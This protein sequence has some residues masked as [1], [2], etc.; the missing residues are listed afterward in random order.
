MS[1]TTLS[2]FKPILDFIQHRSVDAQ[3]QYDLA[4]AFPLSSD[5]VQSIREWCLQGLKSGS[6]RVRGPQTLRFGNLLHQKRNEYAF[7]IDIVDMEGK[8]PGHIHPK[9]EINLCFSTSNDGRGL[10]SFDGL[11]EGWVVKQPNSWHTPHVRHGRMVIIYF[12]PQGKV[13]FD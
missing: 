4:K 1:H 2:V 12:L 7:R 9:G 11:S 13:L 10:T 5:S 8:G 3:L 6:I